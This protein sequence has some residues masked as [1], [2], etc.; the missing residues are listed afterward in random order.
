MGSDLIQGS[1]M[2]ALTVAVALAASVAGFSIAPAETFPSKPVTLVVGFAPGGPTDSSARILAERM[3]DTLGQSVVVENQS[4]AAGTIAYNRVGRADPDGYTLY[5]GNWTVNVGAVTMFPV[6]YDTLKDF[7]PVALLTTSKLWIVARKDLPASNPKEFVAWLKANPGKANAASVGV[8]SAAHVCLVDLKNRS[9]TD[10]QLVTYRGG[11]PAV[12]ALAAGEADFACLEGGQT[13]GLYR[14][15]KV[16]IIGVASNTRWFG[17]P[18]VPTLGEGGVPG[19]EL[20]FWHGLWAPK[21]TPKAVVNKL[22]GSVVKAF[23]NDWVQKR[24]KELGHAL[25]PPD[26][27]TPQALHDH[28]KA[29]VEKW[30]P[31]MKAAGIKPKAS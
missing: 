27:R 4:G 25:P 31:I 10:F 28:H 2:K 7:E 24:F 29:E 17:A 30:W 23:E 1:H 12:Q 13:L 11:A 22:N 20:H 21:N 16:K 6:Q 19:V 15:S 5:L 18:E 14:G 26:K 9:K 3:K 8:G